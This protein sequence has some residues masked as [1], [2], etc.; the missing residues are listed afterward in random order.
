MIKDA[1]H[2]ASKIVQFFCP[3]YIN[4]FRSTNGNEVMKFKLPLLGK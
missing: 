3:D 4:Q 1:E 2:F